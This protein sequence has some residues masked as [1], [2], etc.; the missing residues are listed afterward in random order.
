MFWRLPNSD[1]KTLIVCNAG[2]N[3]LEDISL[4]D[5]KTGFVFAPFNRSQKKLFFNA[6]LIFRFRDDQIIEGPD[7]TNTKYAINDSSQGSESNQ[8]PYYSTKNGPSDHHGYLKLVET[9]IRREIESG[10]N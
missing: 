10:K 5:S 1:E 7:L 4:E 9:S 2:A 6:D 8:S 3:M